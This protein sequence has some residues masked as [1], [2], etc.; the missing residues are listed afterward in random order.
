[1]KRKIPVLNLLQETAMLLMMTSLIIG[2]ITYDLWSFLPSWLATTVIIL[3]ILGFVYVFRKTLNNM[4][5]AF[6]GKDLPKHSFTIKRN[7]NYTLIINL[8]IGLLSF[9]HCYLAYHLLTSYTHL[10][11]EYG[12][13]GAVALIWRIIQSKTTGIKL[14]D[15]G[16][17][18]GSKL[19]MKLIEWESITSVIDQPNGFLLHF[20]K[21]FPIKT[22]E[23][24][25]SSDTLTAKNWINAHKS[26][27]PG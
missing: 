13:G 23:I 14:S 12:I 21:N 6:L 8:A 1:V 25:K 26:S 7:L 18:I 22:I 20:S 27:Q 4:K 15:T 3:C 2:Y 19:D 24:K 17:I 9:L 5:W 10:F 11:W 16:L